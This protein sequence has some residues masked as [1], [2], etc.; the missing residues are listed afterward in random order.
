M[1][2]WIVAELGGIDALAL[3]DLPPAP[4]PGPSEATVE[5]LAVGLNYP[6]LLMLSGGYQYRPA[7]PFTPGMEGVGRIVALGEGLAADLLGARV[8]VGGRTGLL[9]EQVTVPLAQ[10]RPAPETLSD[11]EAAG[12]TTG[13]L[14][15]WVALVE[16]GRLA[17]G[18]RLAVLG[19][20]GGM[21]LAAVALGVALGAEVTAI[22]SAPEKLEAARAAG[23]HELRVIDRAA[24]DL[25]ALKDRFDLVFDPVGGALVMPALSALRWGGR[26]LV[27]GFVG[28]PPVRLPLNRLLLKGVE[29]V[30]VRAGEAGRRDPAAGRAHIAAIDRL[31][32]AGRLVPH[33]GMCVPFGQAPDAFRAMAAGTLCGKAIVRL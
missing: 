30:G 29:V 12:F 8:L 28:G 16:R 21:G 32:A 23:A 18:E 13:A 5:M 27:I 4:A 6:D 1:R 10:L 25:A 31:A 20:G 24:P 9:A 22:A 11:A 7:L 17:A 19:A 14:T 33:V 3:A 15:A 2:A 26:Y